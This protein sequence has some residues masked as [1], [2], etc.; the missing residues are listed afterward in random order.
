MISKVQLLKSVFDS[1]PTV[2]YLQRKLN[3]GSSRYKTL[4]Q[5]DEDSDDQI[6]SPPQHR[7]RTKS[8]D[9]KLKSV[10][11]NYSKLPCDEN[12][13]PVVGAK[14]PAQQVEKA[15]KP[16]QQTTTVQQ[17]AYQVQQVHR[18]LCKTPSWEDNQRAIEK[19]VQR[20]TAV[21]DNIERQLTNDNGVSLRKLRKFMVVENVLHEVNLL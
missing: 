9:L 14:K 1:H 20:R 18:P 17:P 4:C 10:C 8:K 11:F 15:Q 13:D 19:F 7:K 12:S 2:R 16:A 21:C 3:Q 6:E 5:C